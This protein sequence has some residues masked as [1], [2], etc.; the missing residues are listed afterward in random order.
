MAGSKTVDAELRIRAKNLASKDLKGL[1][2]E[3]DQISEAQKR[4]ARTAD[5][6]ATATTTLAA[7]AR[8]LA[9]AGRQL[10]NRR[11]LVER[12]VGGREE[13]AAASARLADLTRQARSFDQ[14]TFLGKEK[15]GNITPAI[16]KAQKELESLVSSYQSTAQQARAMGLSIDDAAAT[17]REIDAVLARNNAAQDEATAAIE[18]RTAAQLRANRVSEEAAARLRQE[19]AERARLTSAT[20]EAVSRAGELAQLRADIEARSAARA[21]A[22]AQ[23]EAGRRLQAQQEQ[24]A[25]TQATV[26]A[27]IREAVA[28]YDRLRVARENA[29]FAFTNGLAARDA[30]EAQAEASRRLQVQQEQEARAQAA[31]SARVR[32]A[33]ADYD[34][35]RVAR[36]NATFAFTKGLAAQER[37]AGVAAASIARQ[38]RLREFLKSERGQRILAAEATRRQTQEVNQNSVAMDR[39][40]KSTRRAGSALAYFDDTGRKS[41]GTYQRLRGQVLGL[42]S[43]YI[44][45]YEAINT[46][47]KAIE[48]TSRDQALRRGLEVGAGGDQAVALRN[49]NMLR[50]VTEELGLVFDDVAPRFT[51]LDVAGQKAGLTAKQTAQAF[52][53]L[54]TAAAARNLSVDDTAGAFRAIEQMFS[55]GRVQ[56]EELR[57]QLAERLPGAV[58]IFAEA[59]GVALDEL[60]KMLEKGQVG[61]DFVVKG[62]RA[63]S[64]QFDDQLGAISE[65]LDAYINRARNAYNDWLRTLL[66]GE[67]QTKLKAAFKVV[68]DFFRGKDGEAFAR[69]LVDGFSALVDVFVFLAKNADTV[70]K[71]LKALFAVMAAKAVTDVALGFITLAKNV[72]A[73][74]VA[75]VAA[76]TAYIGAA[77]ATA[78]LSVQTR[79]LAIAFGP[80]GIAIAAL[81]VIFTAHLKQLDEATQRTKDYTDALHKLGTRQGIPKAATFEESV[82]NVKE[83]QKSIEAMRARLKEMDEI[84]E[85]FI[86][87]SPGAVQFAKEREQITGRILNLEQQIRDE[88]ESVQPRLVQQALLEDERANAEQPTYKPPKTADPKEKGASPEDLQ[89]R[90][91]A[92]QRQIQRAIIDSQDDIAKAGIDS[93]ARTQ[94]QL[95]KNHKIQLQRNQFEYEDQLEKIEGLKAA[96]AAAAEDAKKRGLPVID[97]SAQ[98]TQLEGLAERTRQVRDERANEDLQVDS[99]LMKEAEINRLIDERNAKIQLINTQ[100]EM[101]MIGVLESYTLANQAQEEYNGKIRTLTT[102]LIT[103]LQS[104]DPSSNLYTRLGVP[105]LILGLQQANAE[106]AKLTNTQ[107]FFRKF[108]EEI[109]GGVANSFV[110]LG[111]GIAGF[112]Q[113]ANSLG[114]A[115]KGAMDSFRAFAADFLQQ[116][117]QMIIQAL[118]LQAIQNAINGTSGGYGQAVGNAL[119]GA[120]HTGGVVT[121]NSRIGANPRRLVNPA[122]F[123]GAQYFH[124]GGFPGLPGLR[125]GEVPAILKQGEEVLNENDPRNALNGGLVGG[126]PT[127]NIDLIQSIDSESVVAAALS[128]PAGRKAIMSILKGSANELRT[129]LGVNR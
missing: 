36:E 48:A 27:R 87:G 10:Q 46:V 50:K 72:K 119:F 13:I 108:G 7:Q 64:A 62:L 111:K 118:I 57:G 86:A 1:S 120:G 21:A 98:L 92:V 17:L 112:L 49:Y 52:R 63:Y 2:A 6:A 123:A 44:G 25:R 79:A 39:N 122:V 66:A 61:L 125:Q 109:A 53:D 31:A 115:F 90:M 37:E 55:K 29:T 54:S 97:V 56:A 127:V 82:A 104:I 15:F 78:A 11:T 129:I 18:R 101:G 105:Q 45:V 41:L 32:E 124:D 76:R 126:E 84:G 33:V 75:I 9:E 116:I 24:E 96:F 74:T 106:A 80:V 3:I 8:L 59:N 47:R 38:E 107:K 70:M 81:T 73:A 14:G 28:D 5:Q 43:A 22:E 40:A 51:N 99:I 23:A 12:L 100:R 95:E 20:R 113:S 128:R 26:S 117:A 110:E 83:A 16:A 65:R 42:A 58:A 89:R 71:A 30:A 34:R 114:D 94:A 93:Q 121:G 102:D 4:Q 103:L 85:D 77:G 60:D 91:E 88:Q 19:A 67:G 69:A 35:L 68:E